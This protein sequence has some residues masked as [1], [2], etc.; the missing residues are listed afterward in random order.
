MYICAELVGVLDGEFGGIMKTFLI[1]SLIKS[2]ILVHLLN[3]MR[4][5]AIFICLFI[6]FEG[7]LLFWDC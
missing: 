4:L 1:E 2:A 7:L 6:F 3:T 5:S